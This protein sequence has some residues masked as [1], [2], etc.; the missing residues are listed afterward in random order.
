MHTLTKCNIYCF[1]TVTMVAR[2]R[3][4]VTLYVHRLSCY[5]LNSA[6]RI[7]NGLLCFSSSQASLK[8]GIS[9]SHL[10]CTVFAGV[11][12]VALWDSQIMNT[13]SHC[14]SS[15]LHGPQTNMATVY[16][17]RNFKTQLITILI[18]SLINVSNKYTYK[19]M[20]FHR[21]K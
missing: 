18:H 7:L 6:N 10:H 19:L 14:S 20:M 2:T 11:H 5:E 15:L 12:T 8:F 9:S 13:L 21:N 3:L 17:Y 4:I 1:S 16:Y